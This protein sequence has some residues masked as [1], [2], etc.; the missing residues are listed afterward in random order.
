M[1]SEQTHLLIEEL[2][3]HRL[4]DPLRSAILELELARRIGTLDLRSTAARIAARLGSTP[5]K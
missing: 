4:T 1:N 2:Q 3:V 5:E